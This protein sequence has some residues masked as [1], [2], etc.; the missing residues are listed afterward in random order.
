MTQVTP[1][2]TIVKGGGTPNNCDAGI[3]APPKKTKN[4]R[5]LYYSHDA[6]IVPNEHTVHTKCMWC[7]M[8]TLYTVYILSTHYIVFNV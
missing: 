6:H 7:T 1:K 2:I 4:M 8:Y 5:R 3:Y